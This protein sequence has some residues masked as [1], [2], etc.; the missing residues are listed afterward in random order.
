MQRR[1]MFALATTSDA[2]RSQPIRRRH[3]TATNAI[4]RVDSMYEDIHS[5]AV[6]GAFR[7]RL[8]PLSDFSSVAP[9]PTRSWLC[10]A[11]KLSGS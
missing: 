9:L 8:T 2:I 7:A 5:G 3:R 4:E 10:A 11:L 6:L 1:A